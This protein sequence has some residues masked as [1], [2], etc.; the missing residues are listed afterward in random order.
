[1]TIH[2]EVRNMKTRHEERELLKTNPQGAGRSSMTIN[3]KKEQEVP[4]GKPNIPTIHQEGGN[5][6]VGARRKSL[7]P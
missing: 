2:Q 5:R 7:P 3:Q 4:T 6:L 1:M